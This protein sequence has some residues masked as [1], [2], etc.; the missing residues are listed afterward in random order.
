MSEFDYKFKQFRIHLSLPVTVSIREQA[1]YARLLTKFPQLDKHLKDCF[2][3]KDALKFVLMRRVSKVADAEFSTEAKTEINIET[4]YANKQS[5]CMELYDKCKS[6][7][8]LKSKQKF[9]LT[10]S[11]SNVSRALSQLGVKG[12]L[13]LKLDRPDRQVGIQSV[14][15]TNQSV[16][17]VGRYNKYSREMSQTPWFIHEQ[18]KRDSLEE[19]VTRVIRK[20]IACQSMSTRARLARLSLSLAFV[21]SESLDLE[22]SSNRTFS[23]IL[24]T[25][26]MASGRE[27]IDVRMLGR[28]RP[29]LV[30]LVNPASLEVD[31]SLF[32]QIKSEIKTDSNNTVNVNDLQIGDKEDINRYLKQGEM[33]KQKIY[34]ALCISTRAICQKDVD[35]ISEIKELR[36]EQETPMRVL[37]RRTLSTR[38]K[39]IHELQIEPVE[40]DDQKFYLNVT[41]EA[42]TYVKEFV[43]SDFGRTT[44]SLATILGEC[45]T[46]ILQLDVLVSFLI[47][48][49]SFISLASL[50]KRVF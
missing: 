48:L 7:F 49:F 35:K 10:F 11:H 5:E 41:T 15:I 20:H 26:F 34:R 44:P 33:E 28:G 25:K 37:H 18:L 27:D 29:F 38:P 40:N 45:E 39:I 22:Q 43:N 13:S 50:Y 6:Q 3:V 19:I 47:S 23:Q 4:E 2:K 24:E 31:Q 1:V 21:T 42:G 16:F 8:T 17:L 30:E 12:L 9:D 32:A 36:I 46:D 14:T